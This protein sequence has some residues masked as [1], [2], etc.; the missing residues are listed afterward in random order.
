V[1]DHLR[2]VRRFL[3]LPEP[4]LQ[5]VVASVAEEDRQIE[6]TGRLAERLRLTNAM[7]I[8]RAEKDPSILVA[9]IGVM[10]FATD[11]KMTGSRPETVMNATILISDVTSHGLM[12]VQALI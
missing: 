6:I 12:S 9:T 8:D 5:L 2:L 11:A 1:T 10:T 4:Q 7:R 3:I